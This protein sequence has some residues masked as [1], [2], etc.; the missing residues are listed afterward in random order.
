LVK[1]LFIDRL[2][3][4]RI[5]FI[6]SIFLSFSLILLIILV[7]TCKQNQTLFQKPLGEDFAG[8]YYAGD[9][10]NKD[11]PE[12]LYDAQHQYQ[13]YHQLFPLQKQEISLPYVH[14]P[15]V[16]YFF[17]PISMLPYPAAFVL[18]VV[19]SIGLY[20]AGFLLI[21]KVSPAL[22]SYDPRTTLCV[23]LAFEPF[24]MEC[25]LGG[26]LSTVAFFSVCLGYF[27]QQ[28]NHSF[29]SGMALGMLFY[30]PTLLIVILP[31]LM[32]TRS[33]LSLLGLA[34]TGLILAGISI[35]PVGWEGAFNYLEALQRFSRTTST[36]LSLRSYK[37]VD[38]NSFLR[39]LLGGTSELQV[40]LFVILIVS[41]LS[42][43]FIKWASFNKQDNASKQLIW[44]A[45]LIGT[46]VINFYVGIYD[47]ILVVAGILITID[48]VLNHFSTEAHRIPF[49]LQILLS[50]L[51][52]VS[53]INQ[54][55]AR[56]TNI[57]CYTLVLLS[58]LIYQFSIGRKLA[59]N[60]SRCFF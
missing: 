23:V 44:A 4:T 38:I 28:R 19:L 16:A 52:V 13:K 35:W 12:G 39:L 9:I 40:V 53:W 51:F 2:E 18:W 46:P 1:K 11:G 21:V 56:I 14:P 20:L 5:R 33:G 48:V 29:A 42:V 57:Q 32:V 43:Y 37:Y 25:L 59:F 7:L 41:F 58:L 50:L 8:F 34:V 36:F 22:A 10:L 30:K 47:S 31:M 55:L 45:A 15:V 17:R 49:M 54:P 27:F 3:R 26:Q 24:L 6:C 60:K